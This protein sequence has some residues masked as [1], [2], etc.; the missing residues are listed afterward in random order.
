MQMLQ[1]PHRKSFWREYPCWIPSSPLPPACWASFGINPRSKQKLPPKSH[2]CT[3]TIPETS[4][5]KFGTHGEFIAVDKVS[6]SQ[7][8]AWRVPLAIPATLAQ[9]SCCHLPS[10]DAT[11]QLIIARQQ[12]WLVASVSSNLTRRHL[13][14]RW[15]WESVTLHPWLSPGKAEMEFLFFASFQGK[16]TSIGKVGRREPKLYLEAGLRKIQPRPGAFIEGL[17]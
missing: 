3:L 17:S 7:E 14:S 9:P 5:S 4:L 1:K 2:E 10:L 16:V 11:C 13:Q 15:H 6:L 12:L 8:P